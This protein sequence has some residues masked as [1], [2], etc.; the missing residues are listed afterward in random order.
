[1]RRSAI[2]CLI[3]IQIPLAVYHESMSSSDLI[4]SLGATI[5]V[6]PAANTE[7]P[8]WFKTIFIVMLKKIYQVQAE[9]TDLNKSCKQSQNINKKIGG[10]ISLL[11]TL[12]TVLYY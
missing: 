12:L 10:S 2:L 7:E 6:Q 11:I 8:A 3:D 9:F 5:R 4:P 1:M